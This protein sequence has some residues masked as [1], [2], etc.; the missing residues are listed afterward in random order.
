MPKNVMLNFKEIRSK[1]TGLTNLIRKNAEKVLLV[2]LIV[3][4]MRLGAIM[5]SSNLQVSDYTVKIFDFLLGSP[6]KD[7]FLIL[8]AVEVAVLL[9]IFIGGFSACGLPTTLGLPCIYGGICSIMS[10]CAYSVYKINGVF[11][12]II[13]IVPF[14]VVT[15]LLIIIIS[16]ES[17][18]FTK[19]IIRSLG[20][21]EPSNRGELKLFCLKG[22][23]VIAV[24]LIT[25]LIQSLLITTIGEKILNI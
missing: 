3:I 25:A 21:G 15:S 22:I 19:M 20:Y 13:L 9:V 5:F 16:N 12:A 1:S 10:C 8:S 7:V 11:F 6:I 17:L 14:A 24:A 18:I 23:S 2:L 4:G